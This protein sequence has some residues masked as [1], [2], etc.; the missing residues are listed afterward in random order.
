MPTK[1]QQRTRGSDG[2]DRR[3]RLSKK[4]KTLMRAVVQQCWTVDELRWLAA[5]L[6]KRAPERV[7]AIVHARLREL[8]AASG[9]RD[10]R[11]ADGG[12]LDLVAAHDRGAPSGSVSS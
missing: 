7:A 9:G 3:T 5:H 12:V 1:A 4:D 6:D 11:V 10:G 2:M 8:E